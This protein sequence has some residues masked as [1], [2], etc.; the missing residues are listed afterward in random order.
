M[1]ISIK[2]SL[3]FITKGPINN[4]PALGQIS[5]WRQTIIWINDDYFTDPYLL[6]GFN[7]WHECMLDNKNDN[8]VIRTQLWV[9]IWTILE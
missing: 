3:K 5:A 8:F 4:I 7:E 9:F 6:L 1:Q 2:S